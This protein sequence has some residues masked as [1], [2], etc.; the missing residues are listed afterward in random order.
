M[1]LF[2]ST[3]FFQNNVF[4][5]FFRK[6]YPSIKHF[7]SRSGQTFFGL[8]LAPVISGRQKSPPAGKELRFRPVS[9]QHCDTFDS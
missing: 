6:H 9:L 5:K 2:S 4:K 7:E 8:D 1:F 3:D